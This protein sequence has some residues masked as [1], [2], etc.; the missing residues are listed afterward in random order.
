M[1]C[2]VATSVMIKTNPDVGVHAICR[3]FALTTASHN[4]NYDQN[5][6]NYDIE[7]KEYKPIEHF[8]QTDYWDVNYDQNKTNYDTETKL[9]STANIF[10]NRLFRCELWTNHAYNNTPV[11]LFIQTDC[12]DAN[13]DQ[14]KSQPQKLKNNCIQHTGATSITTL[15][16]ISSS[17]IAPLIILSFRGM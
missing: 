16:R 12:R 14:N 10:S 15:A 11:Q 17:R 7:I 13:H 4:L 1:G 6:T 3:I 9:S 2:V 5:K 8:F